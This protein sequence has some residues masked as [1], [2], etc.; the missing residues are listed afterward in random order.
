MPTIK[1]IKLLQ[2][3]SENN[4]QSIK[5]SMLDAGYSQSSANNAKVGKFI[6]QRV[7]QLFPVSFYA[8]NFEKLFKG[9]KIESFRV[10]KDVGEKEIAELRITIEKFGGG[11]IGIQ[12]TPMGSFAFYFMP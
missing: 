7:E 11:W 1:Q 5:Q 3:L 2:K 12:K 6:N 8:K 10:A 4:N 9:G